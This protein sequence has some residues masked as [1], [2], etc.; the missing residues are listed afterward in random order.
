MRYFILCFLFISLSSYSQLKKDNYKEI[1]IRYV[2]SFFEKFNAADSSVLEY[3]AE[4]CQMTSTGEKGYHTS[5]PSTLIA[6]LSKLK[7]RFEERIFNLSVTGDF[8]TMTISMDY[9]LYFDKKIHHCGKNFFTIGKSLSKPMSYQILSLADSRIDCTEPKKEQ[10]DLIQKLDKKMLNWHKAAAEAN[11]QKYF[12]PMDSNFIYLGTDPSERWTKSSFSEF[13]Q[14][15]F[16]KGKGWDFKTK[17]RNWYQS[18]DGNV[19]WFEELLDTHM[20]LCRGSGVWKFTDGQW[21]ILH[22]NLALTIYNE[23]MDAVKKANV[24]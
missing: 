23:K 6:E 2:E 13:C 11:Y 10:N 15:Y 24:K 4:N 16:K 20:G 3:F 17:W 7:G 21:K 22:Y 1:G 12:T 9:E 19:F 8:Y 18:E 5:S 14:P